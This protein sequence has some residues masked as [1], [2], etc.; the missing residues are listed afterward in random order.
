MVETLI[1]ETSVQEE[2]EGTSVPE[3]AV[4]LDQEQIE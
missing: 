4:V 3:I 2:S 1:Y